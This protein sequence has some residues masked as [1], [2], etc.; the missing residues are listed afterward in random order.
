[1][2]LPRIYYA[3]WIRAEDTKCTLSLSLSWSS[4]AQVWFLQLI[5]TVGWQY[6][7]FKLKIHFYLGDHALNLF[8]PNPPFLCAL[9]GLLCEITQPSM[10]VVEEE[11]CHNLPQQ[12][13]PK[14][15]RWPNQRLGYKGR[16]NMHPITLRYQHALQYEWISKS[17]SKP[18]SLLLNQL[19]SY[20][21]L[22]HHQRGI[23][24]F[25]WT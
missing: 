5:R 2:R 9:C 10:K 16:F 11:E 23:L 21:Y 1:M 18:R 19:C 7:L 24:S 14:R 17:N 20:E 22:V 12:S 13:S 15:G 3:L 6:K 4:H 8:L 25:L